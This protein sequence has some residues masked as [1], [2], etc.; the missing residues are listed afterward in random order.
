MAS[1]QNFDHVDWS[2]STAH[3]YQTCPRQFYYRHKRI[4]GNRDSEWGQSDERPSPPGAAIGSTVHECLKTQIERWRRGKRLS[5]QEAQTQATDQ[6]HSY[7]EANTH[8]LESEYTDGDID[9]DKEEQKRALIRTAHDHIERFFQVIWPQFSGHNYILHEVIKSFTVGGHTVWVR[10][11]LCTRTQD[12]DFVVTDWKTSSPEPFSEQS[13][14][15]LT[16]ALWAYREYEPDLN[17]ILVQLVHT[18]TGE[19]VRT[20]PDIAAITRLQSRIRADRRDW[21]TRSEKSEFPVDPADD[22]CQSC[23]ALHRCEAGQSLLRD[24]P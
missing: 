16:Y 23:T 4:S 6:L 12:G 1:E 17:R 18:G 14:Q 8:I 21:G 5:L 15:L 13:L 20:R 19:F 24:D 2:Y 22:K 7:V 3:S 11:D 9:F 10:P